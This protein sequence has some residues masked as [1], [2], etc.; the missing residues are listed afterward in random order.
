MITRLSIT[1]YALIEQLELSLQP[2]L[3]VLTGETGSGKSIIIGALGLI[4]GQ[5]ADSSLLKDPERKCVV[6]A[7][8]RVDMNRFRELFELNDLD[9][10]DEITIRREIS[11]AGKSRAFIND[12]PVNLPVLAEIAGRLVDLHSQHENLLLGKRNFLLGILDQVANQEQE[13]QLY[14]S[15]FRKLEKTIAELE[16]A[17]IEEDKARLDA[18]YFQFQL[19]ELNEINLERIDA[20]SLEEELDTLENA[21]DIKSNLRSACF[22]LDEDERSVIGVLSGLDAALSKYPTNSRMMSFRDRIKAVLVELRDINS[23]MDDFEQEI[24]IDDERMAELESL[25]GTLNQLLQKHRVTE[26]AELIELRDQLQN[27]IVSLDHLEDRIKELKELIKSSTSDLT[28]KADQ[29]SKGRKQAAKA[30]GEE[31]GKQLNELLMPHA[32][33]LFKLQ[34]SEQLLPDGKDDINLLFKANKGSDEKPIQKVASGGEISR[35]MLAL[36]GAISAHRELPTLILDE[37]DSGVSGEAAARMGK[38]MQEISKGT[39]VISI[40]HL[41]QVAGLADHHFKVQ[42]TTH[43]HDTLTSVQALN[44]EERILEI[45]GLLSGEKTTDAAIENARTLLRK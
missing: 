40:T 33:L 32:S 44:S 43:E 26:L 35:V 20:K 2:G 24:Q 22:S 23:E 17:E 18:D 5:R 3:T 10:E 6:E 19:N 41:P 7:I 37:V 29:I 45:A 9:I 36:K 4:L 14:R 38:V 27:K 30:L 8:F 31:T 15:Q 42:K 13:V 11:S 28:G 12:T 1:N 34:D 39:Q 16:Q 21:G 25:M